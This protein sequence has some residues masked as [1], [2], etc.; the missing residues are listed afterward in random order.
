MMEPLYLNGCVEGLRLGNVTVG[1]QTV[2]IGME[3]AKT[4]VSFVSGE[5]TLTLVVTLIVA[6]WG[7]VIFWRGR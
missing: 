6:V 7:I 3:V 1:N 4:C 5:T 2:Q